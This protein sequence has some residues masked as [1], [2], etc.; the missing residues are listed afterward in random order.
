MKTRNERTFE[1]TATNKRGEKFPVQINVWEQYDKAAIIGS[2]KWQFSGEIKIDGETFPLNMKNNFNGERVWSEALAR[3]LEKP[4]LSIKV[5]G[6]EVLDYIST[7]EKRRAK[8]DWQEFAIWKAI[9]D[10][11]DL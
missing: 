5:N 4:C 9:K 10:E 3:K 11:N 7:I 8:E 1:I 2:W 6:K